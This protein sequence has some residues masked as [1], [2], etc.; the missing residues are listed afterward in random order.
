[1][2]REREGSEGYGAPSVLEGSEECKENRGKE[3]AR[4]IKEKTAPL[5][6]Q[7]PMENAAPLV[8]VVSE[9]L[10]EKRVLKVR[11]ALGASK[12]KRAK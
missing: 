1:M 11:G 4:E 5:A 7:D 8:F 12:G 6:L 2:R 10:K 3:D 9:D